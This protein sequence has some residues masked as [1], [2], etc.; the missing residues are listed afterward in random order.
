MFNRR[1]FFGRLLGFAAAPIAAEQVLAEKE[2]KV[3]PKKVME[4]P[5]IPSGAICSYS[6]PHY[7]RI[8][9]SGSIGRW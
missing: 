5:F 2:V 7:P 9:T 8:I 6:Q 4:A 3:E 1:G